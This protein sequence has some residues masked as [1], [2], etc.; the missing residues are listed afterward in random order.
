MGKELYFTNLDDFYNITLEDIND[1]EGS[2]L[3]HKFYGNSFIQAFE[4]SYPFHKWIPWSFEE[5]VDPKFWDNEKNQ[6]SFMQSVANQFGLKSLEDWY[7]ISPK[8]LKENG[9]TTI[10]IKNG[11]TIS[12]LI[13]TIFKEHTWN[14]LLWQEWREKRVKVRK[15]SMFWN[16]SNNCRDWFDS[17]GQKLNF[18]TMEE[19][20]QVTMADIIN[21]GGSGVFNF[22][23]S[24]RNTLTEIY[25]FYSWKFSK[26]HPSGYWNEQRQREFMDSIGHKLGYKDMEDWCHLRRRD[27]LENGGSYMLEIFH[28]SPGAMLKRI[29]P[30][31]SWSNKHYSKKKF[32]GYAKNDEIARNLMD[33]L[34][35]ELGVK[36]VKDWLKVP[37][38]KLHQRG[39]GGLLVTSGTTR[40]LLKRVYNH[41]DWNKRKLIVQKQAF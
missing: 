20:H 1:Y 15:P 13:S 30:F 21:K 22:Y 26:I 8:Q 11:R 4:T 32:F 23:G 33:E 27:L 12:K 10:L 39:Y 34:G 35:H 19:W 28:H 29:Y 41:H 16:N 2:T 5:K 37:R 36:H 18:K 17:F 24:I 3:F 31:Q 14:A 6:R 25:P 9:G 38:K 7:R 40:K